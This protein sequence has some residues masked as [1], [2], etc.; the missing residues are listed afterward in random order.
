MVADGS[1]GVINRLEIEEHFGV[2]RTGR[3][4]RE[5]VM[6]GE[7][8]GEEGVSGWRSSNNE[9]ESHTASQSLGPLA[10]PMTHGLSW[11]T[12]CHQRE[13]VSLV[14]PSRSFTFIRRPQ[15]NSRYSRYATWAT[16]D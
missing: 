1:C 7:R 12:T 16:K 2:D 8:Q 4:V 9:M 13:V 15:P 14:H 11:S 3:G 5:T 10:K 6:G